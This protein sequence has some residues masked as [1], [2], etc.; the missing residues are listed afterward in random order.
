[1]GG[2]AP[3]PGAP[4][5]TAVLPNH[6]ACETA[7]GRY[8]IG[9]RRVHGVLYPRFL[10]TADFESLEA[11]SMV[12]VATALKDATAKYIKAQERSLKRARMKA[13]GTAYF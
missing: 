10:A 2:A 8:A 9:L 5:A 13:H 4:A 12:L 11:F 7:A 1:M 3:A 6:R